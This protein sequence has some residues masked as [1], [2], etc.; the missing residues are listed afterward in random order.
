MCAK[1]R[2]D[3]YRIEK[4]EVRKHIKKLPVEKLE[5]YLDERIAKTSDKEPVSEYPRQGGIPPGKRQKCTRQVYTTM[6]VA[7]LSLL[8]LKK[9][10]IRGRIERC[11]FC[12]MLHIEE[13]R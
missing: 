2:R 3:P 11:V 7:E 1:P 13:L 9:L 6:D 12:G 8:R 4:E 5:D 10:N